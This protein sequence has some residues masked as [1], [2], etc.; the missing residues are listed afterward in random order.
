LKD[1]KAIIMAGGRGTRLMPL[2]QNLPKP[3]MPILN[4]P[5]IYYI[6]QLL[7]SYDIRDIAITLMHMPETIIDSVNS[8]F[9]LNFHY[10]IE[11][12]PL[13]TA[14]SVKAAKDWLNDNP[15]IVISGDALTNLDLRKIY[16][17]HLKS[18]ADITMAVKEADNPSLYGVVKTDKD[19]F[20]TEF[21]E[22]PKGGEYISNLINCGIYIINPGILKY[23]PKNSMFDFAKDLFPIILRKGKK[24][25]T[26][27]IDKYWCDIGC[28]EEY[29][30]ANM[31]MLKGANGLDR[32]TKNMPGLY[33]IAFRRTY[34][35]KRSFIGL[36]VDIGDNVIIGDNCHIDG[37]ISLSDCIIFDNTVLDVSCHGAIV[38][39]EHYIPVLYKTPVLP[40]QQVAINKPY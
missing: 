36:K 19:G 35:G 22:K 7:I 10:F 34:F 6:I 16:D 20:I 17:D 18:G 4:K 29:F 14:G 40:P 39:P 27:K 33:D 32:Y 37:N 2:T 24:I 13:G 8:Y 28:I 25:F 11:D 3:L 31:D 15:F 21:I 26:H 12:E 9:P 38:T 23:V 30:R 5:V 1:I